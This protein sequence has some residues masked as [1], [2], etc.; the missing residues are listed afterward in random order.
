MLEWLL[1]RKENAS[2]QSFMITDVFYL[3]YGYTYNS[4][5]NE[6]EQT[7][8]RCDDTIIHYI[9]IHYNATLQLYSFQLTSVYISSY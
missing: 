4:K 3:S 1:Y 8:A 7:S 9:S 2:L 5:R 6:S